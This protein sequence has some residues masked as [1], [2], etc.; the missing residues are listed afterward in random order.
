MLISEFARA[1]GLSVDTIRF[2]VRR[3]LII[4]HLSEKGG[5]NPYQVFTEEHVSV[6]KVIRVA[7]S[8]GLSL[9]EIAAL[10]EERRKGRFTRERS[11][12]IMSTQL[13]RLDAKAAEMEAMRSY[14]RDKIAWMKGGEIGSCPDFDEYAK[15]A[16]L[17][18]VLV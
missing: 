16:R 14:L 11:L 17:Q 5:R 13:E 8:L 10:I 7:Q 3:G 18:L 9:K 4:P 6:A 12:K 1:T 15:R 2:Y